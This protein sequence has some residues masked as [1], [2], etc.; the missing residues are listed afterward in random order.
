[1]DRSID[2][3]VVQEVFL[4]VDNNV[5]N[6]KVEQGHLYMNNLVTCGCFAL[7]FLDFYVHFVVGEANVFVFIL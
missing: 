5:E 6:F 2:E 1:M 3:V 4:R 7:E